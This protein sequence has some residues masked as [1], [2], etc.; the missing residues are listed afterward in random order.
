[1]LEQVGSGMNWET[2]IE[3]WH[4]SI[5]RE[6]IA[7]AV[8]LASQAFLEQNEMTDPDFAHAAKYVIKKNTELYRRLS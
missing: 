8:R 2:I 1:V 4:R 6:A 5:T 7:E 3:E